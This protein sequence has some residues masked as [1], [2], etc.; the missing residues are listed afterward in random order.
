M[1]WYCSQNPGNGEGR[2][3]QGAWLFR[4]TVPP[5]AV[6]PKFTSVNSMK[7]STSLR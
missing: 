7:S 4:Q 5:T 2:E 1:F 3:G 6:W